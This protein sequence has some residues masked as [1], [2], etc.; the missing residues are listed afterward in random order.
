MEWF[1]MQLE[2]IKY[3]CS[4]CEIKEVQY[5]ENY[6]WNHFPQHTKG[7]EPILMMIVL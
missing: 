6:G 2:N 1:F 5:L 4:L 7:K 3:K